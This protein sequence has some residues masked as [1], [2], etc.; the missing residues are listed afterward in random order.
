MDGLPT[1]RSLDE[2]LEQ[3]EVERGC[4]LRFRVPLDAKTEPFRVDRLDGLD[5]S[6]SRPRRR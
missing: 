5:D 2:A 6:V 4:R 3:L 1:R